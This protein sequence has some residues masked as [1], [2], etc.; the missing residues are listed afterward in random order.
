MMSDKKITT[1]TGDNVPIEH[2]RQVHQAALSYNSLKLKVLPAQINGKGLPPK[3]TGVG[4]N[5]GAVNRNKINDWFNADDGAFAGWNISLPCGGPNDVMVLDLDVKGK[6]NGIEIFDQWVLSS[7]EEIPSTPMYVTPSGGRNYIFKWDDRLKDTTKSKLGI[8]LRSGIKTQCKSHVILPPSR[9]NRVH[10]EWVLSPQET[11]IAKMPEWLITKLIGEGFG[12]AP[13][14]SVTKGAGRGNENVKQ[15]D[16]EDQVSLEQ[17]ERMLNAIDPNDLEYDEW[18]KVGMAINTQHPGSDGLDLWDEWSQ[19]GT[20]Y[21]AGE[22]HKRWK[23]FGDFGT[24]R[25][26]TLFYYAKK[27]DWE[28]DEKDVQN[29][30]GNAL[31]DIN[32]CYPLV[33]IGNK[34]RMTETDKEGNIH[35]YTITDVKL[36]HENKKVMVG[37][38]DKAKLV[39]P[40]EIWKGWEKRREFEGVGL[41]PPPMKLPDG[42]MNLWFGFAVEPLEGDVKPFLDFVRD[43]LCCGNEKY[44][45]WVLDWVAQMVQEP[46]KKTGTCLVLRGKEGTGKNTFTDTVGKFFKPANFCHMVDTDHFVNKFNNHLLQ[47]VF[48][49]ANEAMWSGNHKEANKLKGIITESYLTIELK[50]IDSF[51][52]PNSTRIAILTN[53]DWSIS[54][55]K[56]SRRFMALHVSSKYKG[57][58]AYWKTLHDWIDKNLSQLLHYFQYRQITSNLRQALET[59][60]LR[61][62]RSVTAERNVTDADEILVYLLH[63]GIAEV[64]P[65]NSEWGGRFIWSNSF[66]NQHYTIQFPK[67]A[68]TQFPANVKRALKNGGYNPKTVQMF[69]CGKNH[70][71]MLLP[72]SPSVLAE[73][74]AN[75]LACAPEELE[76]AGEWR[77]WTSRLAGGE[78]RT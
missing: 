20:R 31:E 12:S 67:K 68:S 35:P 42:F 23:G 29:K 52:A 10:Y 38:K 72:E 26:G 9:I 64:A 36:L 44:T 66:I 76:V 49:V 4:F 37:Q 62:Q 60:E 22:C 32:R 5:S 78:S 65:E 63:D 43:V 57:N 18:L 33:K 70:R 3:K 75:R 14:I 61:E 40:V 77:T 39:N 46:G 24:V 55:G 17:C 25:I 59:D 15:D 54:A 34:V 21:K 13:P 47:S 56:E 41:Y 1:I 58:T 71:V 48:L 69:I 7:G 27:H 51:S 30:V 19:R 11:A 73:A 53:E 50:G 16:L 28:P 2:K 6:S 8:D 74:L 45:T